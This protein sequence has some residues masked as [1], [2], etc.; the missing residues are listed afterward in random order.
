MS[1]SQDYVIKPLVTAACALAIDKIIFKENDLNKS[2]TFCVASAT[3]AYIGMSV[4]N[5]LPVITLPFN[6][7]SGKGLTQRAAEVGCGI[8]ACYVLNKYVMKNTGYRDDSFSKI[9]AFILADI[10]GEYASDFIAGR[11]LSLM[12]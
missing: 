11:S 6:L 10:A 12:A 9:G 7:P 1:T 3:G 4:G 8:G 5:S 2:I